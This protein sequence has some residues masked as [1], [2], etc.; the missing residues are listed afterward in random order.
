MPDYSKI[1]IYKIFCKDSN[2]T[3]VYIGSTINFK[4]RKIE[5]KS[6]CYNENNK[7]YYFKIYQY[8]R[9]NGGWDNFE[10][11]IIEKY[12]CDNIKQ[13]TEREGYWIK[14][15]KATLN[16]QIAGRTYKE[17]YQDN[18]NKRKEYNKQKI[19]C[20]C[21]CEIN[22][23]TLKRHQQSAKHINLINK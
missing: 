11:V 17:Y 23:Y 1:V 16:K 8:I 21:G 14:E 12:P 15:L 10:I 19:I 9:E 13:V 5:H 22:K 18:E 20:S 4:R 3:D 2:I 6:R 7:K